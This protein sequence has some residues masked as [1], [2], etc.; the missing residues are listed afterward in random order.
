[1]D[2]DSDFFSPRSK[3]RHRFRHEMLSAPLASHSCAADANAHCQALSFTRKYQVQVFLGSLSVSTCSSPLCFR[4]GSRKRWLERQCI[5]MWTSRLGLQGSMISDP[6]FFFRLLWTLGTRK[7]RPPKQ[8]TAAAWR[9]SA[10]AQVFVNLFSL[11]GAAGF[12]TPRI[13]TG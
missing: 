8:A 12:R 6:L 11:D 5:A 3:T 4:R 9:F 7:G 2:H 1:M 13:V 10:G